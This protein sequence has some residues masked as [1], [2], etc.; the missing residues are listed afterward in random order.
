MKYN[1]SL[2]MESQ[3]WVWLVITAYIDHSEYTG[4][5]EAEHSFHTAG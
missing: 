4:K 2:S 1:E 3:M 5:C